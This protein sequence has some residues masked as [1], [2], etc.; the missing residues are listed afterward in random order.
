LY[1]NPQFLETKIERP[2]HI[3]DNRVHL[4][5]YFIAPGGHGLKALDVEFMRALHDRVNLVPV[6]AKA[7]T[8]TAKELEQFKLNVGLTLHAVC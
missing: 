1:P 4:C 2:S 8:M 6:I 7:D 3:D 5:L